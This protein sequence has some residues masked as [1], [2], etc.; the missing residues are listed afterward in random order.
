LDF[1]TVALLS[2]AGFAGG[3][4]TAIAGGSRG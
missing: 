1:A 2:G 4:V 3:I